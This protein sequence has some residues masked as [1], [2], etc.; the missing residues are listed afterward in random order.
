MSDRKSKPQWGRL[1]ADLNRIS[2]METATAYASRP[3]VGTGIALAF[4]VLA[5]LAAMVALGGTPG[6]IVVVAAAAFGAYMAINIGAND[7][8]N[9]MGPAVGANALS[10]GAAIAIAAVAESAG[11]L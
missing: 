2:R 10:M 6:G 4:I 5:A 1:D 11:A 9:N 3:L 7:V 8:A